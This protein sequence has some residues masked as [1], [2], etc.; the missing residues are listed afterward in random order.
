[1]DDVYTSA[2]WMQAGDYQHAVG[3]QYG[4]WEGNI[5]PGYSSDNVHGWPGQ[6]D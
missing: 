5:G 2:G 4:L 6:L 3:D 1:V